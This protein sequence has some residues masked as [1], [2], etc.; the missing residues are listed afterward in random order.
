MDIRL[1]VQFI[2]LLALLIAAVDDLITRSVHIIY[3]SGF[4]AGAVILQIVNPVVQFS[5]AVIG[6][7][8]A[9]SLYFLGVLCGSILGTGDIWV[10][11][12]CGAYLGI[13]DSMVLFFRAVLLAGGW[14]LLLITKELIAHGGVS[15]KMTL[16]FVPFMFVSYLSMVIF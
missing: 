6:V 16:P 7:L 9:L 14:G 10:I 3:L 8:F 4:F 11:A 12:L 15:R 13:T 5:A 1:V 2:V